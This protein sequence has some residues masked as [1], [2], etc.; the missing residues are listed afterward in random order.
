M[1]N[2][3]APFKSQKQRAWMYANDPEMAERWQKHT[4][5]GKKLPKYAPK[6]KKTKA[7]YGAYIIRR[8][9]VE[10][11][12]AKKIKDEHPDWT[13]DEIVTEIDRFANDFFKED[14]KENV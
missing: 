3:I 2:K 13:F 10:E 5:K 6:K 7:E 9:N 14:P 12:L 1:L 8:A 11:M 4:P